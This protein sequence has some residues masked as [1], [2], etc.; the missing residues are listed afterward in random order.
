MVSRKQIAAFR[1]KVPGRKLV[2]V[3]QRLPRD[4]FSVGRDVMAEWR[5]VS[6]GLN[7]TSDAES[8]GGIYEY[9]FFTVDLDAA[10]IV[11][12][13]GDLIQDGALWLSIDSIGDEVL[14]QRQRA[15]CSL[16]IDPDVSSA[17]D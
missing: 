7:R 4:S 8:H 11:L 3:H 14:E 10:G 2:A 17:I 1:N 5:P 15:K 13:E 9:V 12:R 6:G 16:S